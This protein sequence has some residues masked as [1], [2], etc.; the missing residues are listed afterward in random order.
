LNKEVEL[1]PEAGVKILRNGTEVERIKLREI[2]DLDVVSTSSQTA[3]TQ[4]ISATIIITVI[5]LILIT[6]FR[7]RSFRKISL[8]R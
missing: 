6:I 1:V 8:V 7:Q 4:I 3:T 2:P 5:V